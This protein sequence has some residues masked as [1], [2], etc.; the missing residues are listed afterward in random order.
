MNKKNIA[1]YLGIYKTGLLE[2]ILPFWIRHGIDFLEKHC[3]DE[4]GKLYF[5][6][7]EKGDPVRMR[8]YVYSE[9]FAAIAYA[10]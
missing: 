1:S 3:Y 10:A 8:R 2:D 6:V 9:S 7:D 5:I 4:Q